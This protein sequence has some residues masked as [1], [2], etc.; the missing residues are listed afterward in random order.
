MIRWVIVLFVIG[1]IDFYAFQAVKTVLNKRWIKVLY[2]AASGLIAALLLYV[3][4]Q[5]RGVLVPPGSY[6]FGIFLSFLLSKIVLIIVL[7]SEDIFRLFST[8]IMRFNGVNNESFLPSRRKFVS[9]M[10]LGI[11]AIPFS[12][13][14]Y[15]M[16]QGKYN[17]KVLSYELEFDDLPHSFDG[18]T[19]TQISDIH[20]G[21]FDNRKKIEYAV[22][23]INQLQS[24]MILFTGDLVNNTTKEM[25]GWKSLFASLKANDGVFSVM[26]NHD[27]GD[28]I[29]WSSEEAKQKN[30]KD[31][32]LLH[33]EMG[34]NL[35][36]NE[37]RFI[38]RGED[39]IALIGV[40]NWGENGF[41]KAG[42]IEKASD[43]ISSSLF[44]IVMSHDP[45]HWKTVIKK[46][47]KNFHLTLSGHTHGMQFGIEIPGWIKW[48]PIQYRYENWAGIYTHQNR[49]INVNRGLGFLAYPGRVGISPEITVIKLKKRSNS[50]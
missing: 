36:R 3:G 35:L 10:A 24:D 42:D 13:L 48:S 26:G 34:W 5:R 49:Y 7:F 18:Y 45:S 44:K 27:Y 14:L 47:P 28:Y 21:S 2:W 22:D 17:F 41:K 15:G 4:T 9:T 1:V 19:L 16:I 25:D 37:H 31:F 39:K 23:L 38:Y 32:Y 46:H 6:I 11:A 29:Q 33:K 8:V 20:S 30:V 40:E 50:A 12:S 43:G